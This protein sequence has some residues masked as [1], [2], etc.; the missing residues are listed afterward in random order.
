MGGVN[1]EP[2][3]TGPNTPQYKGTIIPVPAAA[4]STLPILYWYA[5]DPATAVTTTGTAASLGFNGS[6]YDNV[7]GR[8]R[9]MTALSWKKPKIKFQGEEPFE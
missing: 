6:F 7:D 9:G 3:S 1:Q 8:R 5:Q 2:M 4:N